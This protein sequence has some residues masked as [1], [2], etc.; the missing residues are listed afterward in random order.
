MFHHNIQDYLIRNF[1]DSFSTIF[2]VMNATWIWDRIRSRY[3]TEC[4]VFPVHILLSTTAIK[5]KCNK[6]FDTL[7]MYL[8]DTN[9]IMFVAN[10]KIWFILVD[11]YIMLN[12][13]PGSGYSIITRLA[14]VLHTFYHVTI[15]YCVNLGNENNKIIW[16]WHTD[17]V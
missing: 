12:H 4:C 9:Y 7:N 3:L 1:Q 5:L 8:Q 6:I 10:Q 17:P 2:S 13:V 11:T 16:K 14:V 15:Y